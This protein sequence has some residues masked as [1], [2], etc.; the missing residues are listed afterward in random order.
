MTQTAAA[1]VACPRVHHAIGL[2]GERAARRGSI[3][4]DLPGLVGT[5]AAP[6]IAAA[7][8]AANPDLIVTTDPRF[9]ARAASPAPWA[10]LAAA[11]AGRVYLAPTSAAAGRGRRLPAPRTTPRAAPDQPAAAVD[12]G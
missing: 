3:H 1:R 11:R 10:A 4:L 8:V 7:A 6:C 12:A 5:T 9:H 2:R